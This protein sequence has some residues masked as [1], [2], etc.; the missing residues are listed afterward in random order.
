[1]CVWCPILHYRCMGS[2]HACEELVLAVLCMH[3]TIIHVTMI[4]V[5][6]YRE[7]GKVMVLLAET[8]HFLFL[9]STTHFPFPSF[10]LSTEYQNS[11]T[12][13]YVTGMSGSLMVIILIL[14]KAL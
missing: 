3:V 14:G 2:L 4:H 7:V 1:M 5:D 11:P 9:Y 13:V 12:V 6:S 8:S 10:P